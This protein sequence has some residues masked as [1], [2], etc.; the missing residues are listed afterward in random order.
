VSPATR[1]TQRFCPECGAKA[2][3]TQKFCRECGADLQ[4]PA[5]ETAEVPKARGSAASAKKSAA[6]AAATRRLPPPP[7]PSMPAPLPGTAASHSSTV[8]RS[9]LPWPAYLAAGACGLLAI[10]TGLPW[11]G[12]GFSLDGLDIPLAALF[13]DTATGGIPIGILFIVVS[14][15]AL[16]MAL[17]KPV[18]RP[19]GLTFIVA[20]VVST[21]LMLW[22]VIRVL[23]TS[24]GAPIFDALSIGVWLAIVSSLVVLAGGIALQMSARRV[25]R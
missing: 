5:D 10:A 17:A 20:G 22:Y 4:A 11:F 19:L 12:G 3:K 23:S 14:A 18:T 8:T 13:S 16:G 15:V 1:S 9:D 25:P 24:G 6:S 21:F 2:T 7:P